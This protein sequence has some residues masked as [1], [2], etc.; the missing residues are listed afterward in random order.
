MTNHRN[1]R[2]KPS[3]SKNFQKIVSW[4]AVFQ[5]LFPGRHHRCAPISEVFSSENCETHAVYTCQICKWYN[6]KFNL[7][8]NHLTATLA[9]SDYFLT[10][11]EL[12]FIH[13]TMQ[14]IWKNK[15][16]ASSPISPWRQPKQPEYLRQWSFQFPLCGTMAVYSK[17]SFLMFCQ[18]IFPCL[19]CW[20]FPLRSW[21]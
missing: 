16:N 6:N 9:W 21:L 4:N 17:Q 5:R 12:K 8:K 2:L 7:K 20:F 18:T 3:L 19:F 10:F 14:Y 11:T 15:N 13:G 1:K